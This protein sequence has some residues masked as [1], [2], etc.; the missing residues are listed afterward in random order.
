MTY[1]YQ[2]QAVVSYEEQTS[3]SSPA[4][5]APCGQV[6]N[7]TAV[8]A[9]NGIQLTWNAPDDAVYFNI[10]RGR[11]AGQEEADPIASCADTTYIDTGAAQGITYW[12]YVTAVDD[13]GDEGEP[14]NEASAAWVA[15]PPYD[16]FSGI[17]GSTGAVL[18]WNLIQNVQSYNVYRDGTACVSSVFDFAFDMGWGGCYW[19][20]NPPEEGTSIPLSLR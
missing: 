3:L 16:K 19:G 6:T 14:S 2:V 20:F 5:A 4:S 10:Y 17:G 12:Y 15:P 8:E 9:A 18:S 7:L 13:Y 11:D 1:T